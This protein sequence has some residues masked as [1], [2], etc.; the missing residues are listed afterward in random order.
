MSVLASLF[1]GI[2]GITS[3]GSA[4]SV[5]GDN[6]ANQN[7]QAFKAGNALFESNLTQQ[8]GDVEVGLGSRLAATNTSFSQGAFGSSTRAT[9]LAI[10]GD[11]FF[12]VQ[13]QQGERF[14]TRA[15][16]FSQNSDGQLVT[17]VG[18]LQLLGF[19]IINEVASSTPA[20]INLQSVNSTPTPSTSISISMNLD[21]TATTP[22]VAFDGSTFTSAEGSSNFSVPG[23]VYDSRGSARDTI[24]YFRKSATENQ[25]NYYT[26]TA[27]SNLEP[28]TANYDV[29]PSG[30][31]ANDTV[32]LKSGVLTFDT[33]GAFSSSGGAIPGFSVNSFSA[34]GVASTISPGESLSALSD[35][36]WSGANTLDFDD[37]TLDFGAVAG[38]AAVVT[39]FDTGSGSVATFVD[40]DGQGVGDLQSIDITSSGIVRGIFSNGDSRDL[41]QIPVASFSNVEGLSRV[42]SNL[43]E[44]TAE[45]GT[46]LLGS[47]ASTGRGEI[48]SFSI[49]QSNVD[50]AS[51]FVKI[52]QFQRAFQA[53]ARTI[54]A[55]S[56]ILQDL[57]N[58]GR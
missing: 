25:W 18:G 33:S 58:L 36:R 40:T 23:V 44:Q 28:N 35:I 54:T 32:I 6:I 21:P 39:Q 48:R 38:S 55:A 14:F 52:I 5:S 56:D 45:S 41:Y 16:S 20:P 7:T 11:G 2:S 27:M 9:D 31:P 30:N 43:F 50:L 26:L 15:G 1:S 10:Q 12:A 17:T 46:A 49:E 53:S 22:T 4:L 29:A 3:N 57:V 47:A 19:E 37:F 24:T 42:G 8:I 51:E 13:N 34:A